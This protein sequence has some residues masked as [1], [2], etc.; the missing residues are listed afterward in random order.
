MIWCEADSKAGVSSDMLLHWLV[1]A[2]SLLT[3]RYLYGKRRKHPG[4]PHPPGPKGLPLVGNIRDVPSKN[5]WL[6]YARWSID[7]GKPG[8]QSVLAMTNSRRYIGSDLIRMNIL[9]NNV[10]IVNSAEA[11]E[12]LLDKKGAIYSDR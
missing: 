11:A 10:V 4:L 9:G 1:L 12:D 2:V 6:T 7:Y 3:F 5:A 8:L